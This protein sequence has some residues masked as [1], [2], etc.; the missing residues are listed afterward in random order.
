MACTRTRCLESEERALRDAAPAEIVTVGGKNESLGVVSLACTG[1]R[2]SSPVPA[3]FSIFQMLH[4]SEA[5]GLVTGGQARASMMPRPKRS[6]EPP[7]RAH[8][9][10]SRCG[11]VA[12]A[13][14]R[15]VCI[16]TS[17]SDGPLKAPAHMPKAPRI[18]T[19]HRYGAPTA[20]AKKRKMGHVLG[21]CSPGKPFAGLPPAI[22]SSGSGGGTKPSGGVIPTFSIIQPSSRRIDRRK[23]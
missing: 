4:V 17:S 19:T 16:Y 21:R 18:P 9:C 7:P 23:R 5:V 1:L 14:V 10:C 13:V 22:V 2:L 6:Q 8:R 20:M 15:A 3:A 11:G 12:A